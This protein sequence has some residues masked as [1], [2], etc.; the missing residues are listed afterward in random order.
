MLMRTNWYERMERVG[1]VVRISAGGGFRR[2]SKQYASF[3]GCHNYHVN[4]IQAINEQ[5]PHKVEKI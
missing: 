5:S 2:K 1:P 4:M 3:L